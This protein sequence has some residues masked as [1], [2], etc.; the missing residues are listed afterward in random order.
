MALNSY[1]TMDGKEIGRSQGVQAEAAGIVATADM[2]PILLKPK[3]NMVSEVIVHGRHYADLK[4]SEYR[5]VSL[6]EMLKHVRESF[7]RLSREYEILVIEGAGSP[8]EIN[9]KDRDIANM[10]IAEIKRMGNKTDSKQ[11]EP[12]GKGAPIFGVGPLACASCGY[13]KN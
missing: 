1:V 8:A 9:L 11:T 7:T 6:S 5:K 3:K 4:A 13:G 2:N 10:R 12:N